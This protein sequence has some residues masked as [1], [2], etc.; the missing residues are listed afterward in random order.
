MFGVMELMQKRWPGLDGLRGAAILAVLVCHY[1]HWLPRTYAAVGVLEFGWAGVDLFFV[2]SGFLITGILLDAKGTPHFFRNFYA[3]RVLRIFPLYYGFLAVVLLV[4]VLVGGS[5][6][7]W[8]AQPWLWTYTANY[9]I[10]VQKTWSVWSEML[11]PLWSLSVEEQ[12]YLVWPLVVFLFSQRALV[13]IC[14]GVIVGALVLR[15]VLTAGGVSYF[16]VYTWTPTRADALAAGA[17]VALLLRQPD[18]ER[19]VRKLAKFTGPIAL[20]LLLI[21]SGGFDPT[22]H[23]WLRVFLYSILAMLLAALL[24][25][26]IDASSLRGIPKRFYEL[27][28]LRAIGMYSYGIYIFHLPL[29]YM[30]EYALMKRGWFNPKGGSWLAAFAMIALNMLLVGI[31]AFVSFHLYEKQFLKLKRYFPRR[32]LRPPDSVCPDNFAK[33]NLAE[34]KR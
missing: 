18:G 33:W 7:L 31:V 34:S 20:V 21:F 25:W 5:P 1:S 24:F 23:P 17:L 32:A 8:R 11:I 2:L 16:E 29:A 27:R 3:R 28:I 22:R 4:L 6:Q 14:V 30:S 13:W 26:S 15:L 9:W 12:F 10:P 19:F